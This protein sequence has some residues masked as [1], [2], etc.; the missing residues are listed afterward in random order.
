MR[1]DTRDVTVKNA[2]FVFNVHL[3]SPN[4]ALFGEF[5]GKRFTRPTLFSSGT[6]VCFLQSYATVYKISL[7]QLVS[8]RAPVT[9]M[10]HRSCRKQ[11]GCDRGPGFIL[12][13][14]P[15]IVFIS[16]TVI[17]VVG[18]LIQHLGYGMLSCISL[19]A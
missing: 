7:L 8:F 4:Y 9:P 6:L 10:R 18:V 5:L 13:I 12:P 19:F 14:L 11:L 17:Q 2:R 3:F 16:W 15:I 1:Q